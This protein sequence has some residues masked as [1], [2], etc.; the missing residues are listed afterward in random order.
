MHKLRYH[1]DISQS[2]N[3]WRSFRQRIAGVSPLSRAG[4]GLHCRVP[5]AGR[6]TREAAFYRYLRT[7]AHGTCSFTKPMSSY[8]AGFAADALDEHIPV[9]MPIVLANDG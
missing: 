7:G 1:K 4:A 2:L 8:Y 9:D 6:I 3:F 5:R